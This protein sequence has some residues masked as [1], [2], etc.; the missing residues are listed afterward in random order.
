MERRREVLLFWVLSGNMLLD[1]LE[2]SVVVVALP[3][4]ARDLG[5]TPAGSHWVM[6]GFALGFGGSLMAGGALIAA[7]GRRRVYLSATAAFVIA[8][9]VIATTDDPGVAIAARIA[10]GICAGLT[11]PLGLALIQEHHRAG[12]RRDHA[13]RLYARIGALGFVAG[14]VAGGMF[15]GY[16]WRSSAVI[17]A[18]AC[19]VLFVMASR[20]IPVQASREVNT[21]HLGLARAVACAAAV[22]A[23]VLIVAEPPRYTLGLRLLMLLL[24]VGIVVVVIRRARTASSPTAYQALIARLGRVQAVILSAA[25][26]NGCYWALLLFWTYRLQV[27]AGWT[28]WQTGVVLLPAALLT[29]AVPGRVSRIGVDASARLAAAGLGLVLFGASVALATAQS[30]HLLVTSLCAVLLVGAGF[31]LA[32]PCLHA[33]VLGLAPPALGRVVTAPYQVAVQTGGALAVAAL[34][35]FLYGGSG[36]AG[37]APGLV[38]GAA[39]AAVPTSAALVGFLAALLVLVRRSRRTEVTAVPHVVPAG[40]VRPR[41]PI[42]D[43]P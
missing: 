3:T 5:M 1:A 15:T 22:A 37:D 11:A 6:S 20:L 32:F 4:M 33:L 7:W 24:V 14:L 2:V 21:Q 38:A 17:P 43:T 10:K 36:S 39:A 23:L 41:V 12:A 16:T 35:H 19:S 30:S 29:V 8:S 9:V 25:A 40:D 26:L 28:P 18:V 27:G 13:V 31:A 34:G 42:Q